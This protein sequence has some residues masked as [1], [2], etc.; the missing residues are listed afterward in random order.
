M[1]LSVIPSQI[2]ELYRNLSEFL[3]NQRHISKS[4]GAHRNVAAVFFAFSAVE[5]GVKL[6]FTD[7]F[8]VMLKA[9]ALHYII[10]RNRIKALHNLQAIA[11]LCIDCVF[12]DTLKEV[13]LNTSYVDFLETGCFIFPIC[14][15]HNILLNPKS[16]RLL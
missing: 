4:C 5:V 8:G 7:L 12:F 1:T 16:V 9:Q 6:I 10:E 3:V 11:N 15:A 13:S 14:V 2:P